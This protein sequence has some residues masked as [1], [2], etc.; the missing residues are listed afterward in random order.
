M[1][2]GPVVGLPPPHEAQKWRLWIRNEY[3]LAGY[4]S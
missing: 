4:H 1:F 2:C 3:A